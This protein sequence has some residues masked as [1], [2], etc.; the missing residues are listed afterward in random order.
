MYN[1]IADRFHTGGFLVSNTI[2]M[3]VLDSFIQENKISFE[4]LANEHVK[5]IRQHKKFKQS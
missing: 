5:K 1:K 4:F 3:D 2:S